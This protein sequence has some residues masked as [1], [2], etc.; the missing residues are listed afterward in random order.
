MT[1][2][3]KYEIIRQIGKGA[4]SAVFLARDPFTDRQVAVKVVYPEVLGDK[5]YGRRYRKLF[6]TEAS[7]AGMLSHPHIVAIYDAAV[8]GDFSY[9]VMEYV[10]GGT[11]ERHTCVDNLLPINKVLEIAFK[12]CKSLD[13]AYRNG[14]I[15][16]DI[17]P[18][19]ILLTE[20]G[21]MKISDF[22]AALVTSNESTQ[23][24]GV[25]SPA[26]M[27]PQQL[28]E[29]PLTHQTDIF[30][31]GVVLY[32]LFTG[33]LPFKGANKYAMIYQ[34]IHTEP[35]PPSTHRP[36]IPKRLDDIV[37]K[38]LS[39]DLEARYQTWDEFARD[40]ADAFGELR[41]VEAPIPDTEKF[42]TLRRLKFF[43]AFTDVELWE[44]VRIG[45]WVR[46]PAATVLIREGEAGSNFY[47][48]ATGEVSV[49][50]N[51][52]VLATLGAGDA[53]GEMGH[54]SK[55]EFRRSASVT[56]VS[57]VTVLEVGAASLAGASEECRA[58]FNQVF[59]ETLV[60]RLSTANDRVAESLAD[61][62]VLLL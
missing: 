28:K 5:E 43:R 60:E 57:E 32:Q 48:V 7:L 53:F 9:I 31:L 21:D 8:E 11:L 33:Q 25:G 40:L 46:R 34:I 12:C 58:R 50:K 3:G 39:K 51:R 1:Q 30:A 55:H 59:L 24:S 49:T 56:A 29:Q 62:D 6:V 17:K 27:S 23:V 52:A 10:A 20:A 2:I 44:V 36:D 37:L 13:Y 47:V 16:R 54:L 22:G 4:T 19:N 15:H 61:R 26:Y 18:A 41:R 14:V 35:L 38:A 45:T 42:Y